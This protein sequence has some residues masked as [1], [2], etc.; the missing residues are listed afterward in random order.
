[1]C[2]PPFDEW[3]SQKVIANN[4]FIYTD[5]SFWNLPKKSFSSVQYDGTLYQDY[6]IGN[7]ACKIIADITRAEQGIYFTGSGQWDLLEVFYKL[8]FPSKKENISTN[9]KFHFSDIYADFPFISPS[10]SSKKP[11]ETSHKEWDEWYSNHITRAPQVGETIYAI[12]KAWDDKATDFRLYDFAYS[13]EIFEYY[14]WISYCQHADGKN[15]SEE[16]KFFD[17]VTNFSKNSLQNSQ[18]EVEDIQIISSENNFLYNSW[19][20]LVGGIFLWIVIMFIFQK[21]FLKK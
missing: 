10:N 16:K 3:K 15:F 9:E 8:T 21:F 12:L 1:M 14:K 7:P 11:N 18:K 5:G 17:N 2:C 4:F 19:I 20:F 13:D 6:E